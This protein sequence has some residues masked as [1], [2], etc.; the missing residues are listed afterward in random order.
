ME[1]CDTETLK[2]WIKQKNAQSPQ[3]SKRQ[4][5]SLNIA[6]QIVTGVEYIHSMKHIHRDLKV[7]IWC[8][9]TKP[10]QH[11]SIFA[12]T[13]SEASKAVL[14]NHSKWTNT[15]L[16]N[17]MCWLFQFDAG[18]RHTDTFLNCRVTRSYVSTHHAMS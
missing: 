10:H 8:P 1:L 9:L 11:P 14:V 5:E 13:C 6:K 17:V 15:A 7:S 2:K 18:L 4:E 3:D 12:Q 16:P